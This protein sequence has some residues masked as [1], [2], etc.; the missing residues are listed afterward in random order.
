MMK[1]KL[2]PTLTLHLYFGGGTKLDLSEWRNKER[3]KKK[4]IKQSQGKYHTFL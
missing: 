2:I 1:M 4:L 3:K